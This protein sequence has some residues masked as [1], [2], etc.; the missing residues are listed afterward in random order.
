MPPTPRARAHAQFKKLGVADPAAWAAREEDHPS[1]SR[2]VLLTG[3]W[4][5]VEASD[6]GA[7]IAARTEEEDDDP[8]RGAIR[9][10]LDCGIDPA[11]LTAVVREMQISALDNACR[12][13]DD[14]EHGIEDLREAITEVVEWQLAELDSESGELG[15]PIEELHDEFRE[16][17]PTGRRG[18]PKRRPRRARG[19]RSPT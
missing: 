11:D 1:L 4:R 5:C 13:L 2:W 15:R 6:D 14:G 12:L 7:W 9:R 8:I 18:Q 19:T 3:L 10:M 16:F 17:D